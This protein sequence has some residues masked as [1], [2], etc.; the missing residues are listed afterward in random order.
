MRL[1]LLC[2]FSGW[3]GTS[4]NLGYLIAII[5]NQC[6]NK[7]SHL[8]FVP[9]SLDSFCSTIT[10]LWIEFIVWMFQI[11]PDIEYKPANCGHLEGAMS[12]PLILGP[13]FMLQ[14]SIIRFEQNVIYC[15]SQG[16]SYLVTLSR[17]KHT[18]VPLEPVN[19]KQFHSDMK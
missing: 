19:Q 4:A 1:F 10:F 2:L 7:N 8:V 12:F 3:I 13:F 17:V 15:L 5:Y 9:L 11:R 18:N 16:M 14:I 6:C